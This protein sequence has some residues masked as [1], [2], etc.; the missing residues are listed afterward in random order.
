MPKIK[1][2][3]KSCVTSI[4]VVCVIL[5]SLFYYFFIKPDVGDLVAAATHNDIAKIER[6]LRSG[7]DVNEMSKWGWQRKINGVTP[8][9]AALQWGK[10]STITLLI[11]SG[12]NVNLQD[13][14]GTSPAC[15]AA[16]RGDPEM[17]KLLATAGADFKK[18]CNK[19]TPLERA[20]IAGHEE[21]VKLIEQIIL[22]KKLEPK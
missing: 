4:L 9:T 3:V 2:M 17:I 19:L 15:V 16:R 6:C 7:V 21:A 20:K 11:R 22:E 18:E 14:F 10:I 1:K 5:L 12:A 8:L 13:G